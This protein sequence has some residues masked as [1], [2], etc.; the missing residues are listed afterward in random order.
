M[1]LSSDRAPRISVRQRREPVLEIDNNR[2]ETRIKAAADGDH[3]VFLTVDGK[4]LSNGHQIDVARLFG[5]TEVWNFEIPAGAE[6]AK[7]YNEEIDDLIS[8]KSSEEVFSG[9]LKNKD[10]IFT[11]QKTIDN[12]TSTWTRG[13]RTTRPEEWEPD[14]ECE[15]EYS[16]WQDGSQTRCAWRFVEHGF[17]I[18]TNDEIENGT[19]FGLVL[20]RW[21]ASPDQIDVQKIVRIGANA[22]LLP[23]GDETSPIWINAVKLAAGETLEIGEDY[24]Y[25]NYRHQTKSDLSTQTTFQL[26]DENGKDYIATSSEQEPQTH[27]VLWLDTSGENATVLRRWNDAASAWTQ[28]LKTYIKISPIPTED[29]KGAKLAAGDHVRF[30][31]TYEPDFFRPWHKSLL[32][33][34]T[35]I[36]KVYDAKTVIVEGILQE[37]VSEST[38]AKII[39]SREMPKMEHITECGNR[40]WG[41]RYDLDNQI[42]ELYACKLGDFTNWEAYQGLSTDSWRA[43]RGVPA[44]YTGAITLDNHPLFFREDSLEKI[45]PSSSGAHQVATY[46]LEGVQDGCANS[47]VIID[48]HLFYKGRSGICVY[49]GTM[50]RRISDEFADW[51][52]YEATAARHGRKYCVSMTRDADNTRLCMIYDTETGDWHVEDEAWQSLA[53]TWKDRLYYLHDGGI[54]AMDGGDS[55]EV[56]WHAETDELLMDLPEH[57]FSTYIRIRFFLEPDAMCRVFI[58]ADSRHW[59]RKGE[60]HGNRMDTQEIVIRPW[61]CDHLRLRIEGKGGCEIQSISYRL[62]RS[63]GGH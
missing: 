43:S 2:I 10:Y 24:G 17:T 35:E 46:N 45:Y 21:Q 61:R 30:E 1:N 63:Q 53:I 3:P 42:N 7:I 14:V 54:L 23:A 5:M 15:T 13:V 38:T 8:G 55:R 9:D 34:V 52:F 59:M 19:E 33:S 39:I 60:L 49:S 26:C 4:I 47:L 27:D 36:K 48:N 11:I 41:C 57:K 25:I 6:D 44:P 28:V 16:E 29:E 58:M 50:P 18:E 62:E 51:T 31:T 12:A 20:R 56:E 22:V 37:D 32:N 40:L